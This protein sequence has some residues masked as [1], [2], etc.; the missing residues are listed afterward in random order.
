MG[1]SFLTDNDPLCDDFH[2]KR[3]KWRVKPGKTLGEFTKKFMAIQNEGFETYFTRIPRRAT[4]SAART[5]IFKFNKDE[6][7]RWSTSRRTRPQQ[8]P[9]QGP[10]SQQPLRIP[11]PATGTQQQ[12]IAQPRL[13]PATSSPTSAGASST[14]TTA[15]QIEAGAQTVSE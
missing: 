10:L 2:M 1:R 15:G 11:A 3:A 5:A 9:V 6:R 12:P 8:V 4:K 14:T 13:I 7:Q